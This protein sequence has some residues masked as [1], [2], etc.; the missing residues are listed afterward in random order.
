MINLVEPIVVGI[1]GY[2]VGE[3]LGVAGYLGAGLI[4]AGIFVVERATHA[5]TPFAPG[6]CLDACPFVT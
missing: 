2:F 6:P 3:R 5:R 4:V 1:A